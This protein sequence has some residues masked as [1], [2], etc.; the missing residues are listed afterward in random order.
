MEKD[1]NLSEIHSNLPDSVGEDQRYASCGGMTDIEAL[2]DQLHTDNNP[3]PGDPDPLCCY[4][5]SLPP[6]RNTATM[7]YEHLHGR[8]F[9]M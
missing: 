4:P 8:Y 2:F 1:S 3:C 6:P 5:L 9:R 7:Q